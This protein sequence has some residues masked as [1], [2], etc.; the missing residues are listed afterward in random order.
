VVGASKIGGRT[1][2]S[3][4]S[5]T[6][7]LSP[8]LTHRIRSNGSSIARL[9]RSTVNQFVTSVAWGQTSKTAVR[10][11]EWSWSSWDRKTQRTSA[12]ST[13]ENAASIHSERDS[14]FPVSTITGSAAVITI[15]LSGTIVP[16]G[17]GTI[18]GTTQVSGATR[19]G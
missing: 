9:T 19:Y 6:S 8:G 16:G 18:S 5:P 3:V 2:T 13:M 14:S 17:P 11:P 10:L 7:T 12:G 1:A 15:E 4:R